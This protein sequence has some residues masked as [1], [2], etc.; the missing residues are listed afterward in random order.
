M[1]RIMMLA[2]AAAVTL[3][4]AGALHAQGKDKD[5]DRDR[6]HDKGRTEV[7]RHPNNGRRVGPSPYG[8]GRRVGPWGAGGVLERR[9]ELRLTNPQITRLNAIQRRWDDRN[10]LL[11]PRV[12]PEGMGRTD[13]DRDAYYRSH[14][15]AREADEALRKNREAERKEVD[16]VLTTSQRSK[17]WKE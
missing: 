9:V 14:P 11:L 8:P 1:K 10:R 13:A 3:T 17:Y 4:S 6:G 5:K 2:L 12:T 16:A 7:M 15:Y